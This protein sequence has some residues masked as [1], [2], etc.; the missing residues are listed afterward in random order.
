[1]IKTEKEKNKDTN[2]GITLIALVITIIVLL[3]LAGVS[4][5][6]LTGENGIITRA[7]N[8]EF[9][10]N[11]Y[12]IYNLNIEQNLRDYDSYFFTGLFS[13]NCGSIKNLIIENG[14]ND[15]NTSSGN[16]DSI[17]L[18]VGTNK[19]EITNC[20]YLN[21]ILNPTG[22]NITITTD[23]KEKTSEAMKQNGFVDELNQENETS[24]WKINNNINQ[25][26]PIL[27]WQ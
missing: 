16:F 13:L 5:A 17:A 7:F 8:G 15:S 12:T 24:I 25:G 3:I 14:I 1:M 6:T 27:Y 11:G 9:N 20:Y 19:G 23:G 22:D 18:M 21:N 10:G 2:K 4:I 26:Y